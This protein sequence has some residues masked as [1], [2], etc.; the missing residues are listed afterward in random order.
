MIVES[1]FGKG[2]EEKIVAMDIAQTFCLTNE[3]AVEIASIGAAVS[4][5][6]VF[7]LL[8]SQSSDFPNTDEHR[9]SAV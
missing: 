2:T 9:I 5:T 3:R 4:S 8:A 1:E 6:D 7:T